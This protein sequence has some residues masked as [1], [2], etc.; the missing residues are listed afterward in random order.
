MVT[1]KA[2]MT[3][4]GLP[5]YRWL[6]HAWNFFQREVSAA[7]P[8]GW[9][10]EKRWQVVKAGLQSFSFDHFLQGNWASASV[11]TGAVFFPCMP[12]QV[13]PCLSFLLIYTFSPPF[14]LVHLCLLRGCFAQLLW[15]FFFMSYLING[16]SFTQKFPFHDTF[17]TFRVTHAVNII[18]TF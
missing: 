3:N 8:G 6:T 2:R 10:A 13:T 5:R 1:L 18:S 16:K 11:V 12:P 7:V 9:D 14:L 4:Y 17:T 15:S